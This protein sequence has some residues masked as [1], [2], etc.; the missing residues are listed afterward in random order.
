VPSRQTG[1]RASPKIAFPALTATLRCVGG[2]R[3]WRRFRYREAMC[4]STWQ[5]PHPPCPCV[6]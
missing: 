5:A 3:S 1:L 2:A 4:L 6:A